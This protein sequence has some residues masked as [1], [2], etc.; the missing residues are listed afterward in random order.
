LREL[1]SRGIKKNSSLEGVGD[2]AFGEI[3]ARH[4]DQ[5]LGGN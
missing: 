4:L 5:H 1:L 2:A 3:E